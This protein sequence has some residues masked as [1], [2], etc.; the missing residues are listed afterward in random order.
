MNN[1]IILI[2]ITILYIAF[3][4]KQLDWNSTTYT[5]D[6][7]YD[8]LDCAVNEDILL[9]RTAYAENSSNTWILLNTTTNETIASQNYEY[10]SMTQLSNLTTYNV[11]HTIA[12]S[13]DYLVYAAYN[14]TTSNF[15]DDSN[16]TSVLKCIYN[17]TSPENITF[18]I[19]PDQGQNTKTF[20]Q[21]LAMYEDFLIVSDVDL[22]ISSQFNS[23]VTIYQ[24]NKT[25]YNFIQKMP[26][27]EEN[28][29]IMFI[30]SMYGMSVS[31]NAEYLVVS[32]FRCVYI[33]QKNASLLYTKVFHAC[34]LEF[35]ISNFYGIPLSG[36]M[37]NN[38][39]VA[40]KLNV[41]FDINFN[42]TAYFSTLAEFVYQDT[43]WTETYTKNLSTN[44]QTMQL[45]ES[46]V[47]M[48]DP[49]AN[50]TE[51]SIKD[52]FLSNGSFAVWDN[53]AE[54]WIFTALGKPD[55]NFGARVS[56]KDNATCVTA[57]R[58]GYVVL[59][60]V[61]TPAPSPSYNPSIS[62]EP[63]PTKASDNTT[64]SSSNAK[65]IIIIVFASGIPVIVAVLIFMI[66]YRK[67]HPKKSVPEKELLTDSEDSDNYQFDANDLDYHKL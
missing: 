25:T 61:S 52:E 2:T 56:I 16:G 43:N 7:E 9:I 66:L 24:L 62:H 64:T 47:L 4:T 12:L 18:E 1:K 33:Y 36:I 51:G 49:N 27:E 40:I 21:I 5:L 39:V 48:G 67:T 38:T 20:G 35:S 14:N 30:P 19:A 13:K 32:S 31:M 34:N 17:Y 65:I 29:Y 57:P 45:T 54:E 55:A 26:T 22:N 37:P 60:S 42:P 63:R 15:G 50:S 53:Q 46:I 28:N 10:L 58:G 44:P 11:Y 41:S 6:G 3:P 59:Y 8:Q 23:S